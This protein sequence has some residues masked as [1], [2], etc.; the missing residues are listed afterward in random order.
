MSASAIANGRPMAERPERPPADFAP[1][2]QW[3]ILAGTALLVLA[4]WT[5]LIAL[6]VPV[7]AIPLQPLH[8]FAERPSR[9]HSL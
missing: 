3:A 2:I 1:A 6:A 8:A 5:L 4:L 7:P 9:I